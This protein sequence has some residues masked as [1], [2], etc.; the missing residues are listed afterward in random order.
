MEGSENV[1]VEHYVPSYG[2]HTSL[3]KT[4]ERRHAGAEARWATHQQK[5]RPLCLIV[6]LCVGQKYD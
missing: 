5:G 2:Y 4:K 6:D 1:S 3:A